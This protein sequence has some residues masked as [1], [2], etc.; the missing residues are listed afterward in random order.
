MR[1]YIFEKSL[2][3]IGCVVFSFLLLCTYAINLQLPDDV[4]VSL[5]RK[6][7]PFGVLLI[8]IEVYILYSLICFPVLNIFI[9]TD[10]YT[11]ILATIPVYMFLL[12]SYQDMESKNTIY[13]WMLLS[14]PASAL[15]NVIFRSLSSAINLPIYNPRHDSPLNVHYFLVDVCLFLFIYVFIHLLFFTEK[16]YGLTRSTLMY[17]CSILQISGLFL[18]RK[19][20]KK[21]FY[22]FLAPYIAVFIFLFLFLY[23][24]KDDINFEILWGLYFKKIILGLVLPMLLITCSTFFHFRKITP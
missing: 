16:E 1:T 7:H 10:I 18:L 11:S 17:T 5:Y 8:P 21:G 23:F 24:K 20:N 12:Y 19:D 4:A 3:F 9:K 13:S 22:M 6:L 15:L 14:F 2:I